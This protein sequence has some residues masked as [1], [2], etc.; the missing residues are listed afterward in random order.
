M[1]TSFKRGHKI[2]YTGYE[3]VYIDNQ[4]HISNE[5]KL[6]NVYVGGYLTVALRR[7]GLA[8]LFS[9]E[10]DVEKKGKKEDEN[11]EATTQKP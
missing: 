8:D 3:W 4:E 1:A 10:P 6:Y 5:R 2:E 7:P 11:K 9:N